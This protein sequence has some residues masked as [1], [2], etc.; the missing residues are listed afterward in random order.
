MSEIL[1]ND[2][3]MEVSEDH[4]VCVE[5]GKR[6]RN[7]RKERGWS[8]ERLAEVSGIHRNYVSDMERGERNVSLKIINRIAKAMEIKI[9]DLFHNE[10]I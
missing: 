3:I 1:P 5:F 7:L 2:D 9:S 8:Q 10:L 4:M 6:V